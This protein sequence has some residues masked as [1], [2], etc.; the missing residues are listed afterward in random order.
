M[1]KYNDLIIN[2]DNKPLRILEVGRHTCIRVYR[3][4]ETLK[5]LGYKVDLLTGVISYGT[6]IFD[7]VMFYHNETQFKNFLYEH[8]NKYDI[9]EVH[10]E[11]DYIVRWV[12]EVIG[13][14]SKTKLVYNIHDID[15]VRR[16]FI[17]IDE[18]RAFNAADG[19][20]YV[21]EPIQEISNELHRVTV[22]TMIVYN[23]PTLSMI[24]NTKVDWGMVKKPTMVYEG[25]V[26]A[27]DDSSESREIRRLFPYRNLFPIFKQL[28]EQGNEVHVFT[29][30]ATAYN[31]GQ[32]TGCVLY[33]PTPFD[34]LL[35]KLTQFKY[36]LLT[37]NNKGATENQVNYTTANKM[38]DGLCAGLPALACWCDE[39]EKYVKK[40][41]I[42][43]TFNDLVDIG[44][45]SQLEET[46]EEK[47]ESIK[48]K[49]EELV[50][51]N[52]IWKTENMYAKLLGVELKGI[53]DYIKDLNEFE[54]GEKETNS[55]LTEE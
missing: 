40:H 8:K 39:T 44:D 41:N 19:I 28:I 34:I 12:R 20:V 36:N 22:P 45:C 4:S 55:L 13:K 33:P 49:R 6:E 50:F 25:G 38:W 18:R 31:T 29:G 9:I 26:N 14:D 32:S 37:F 54:Y 53:P 46:Y 43:W 5:S 24:N 2:K 1:R 48:K 11:P 30:N 7:R 21:S 52:H 23:Y 35:N 47:I 27:L 42:G 15:S 10:N 3:F 51:S 17:P 16:N